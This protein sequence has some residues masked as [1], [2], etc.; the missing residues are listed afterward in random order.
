M[1]TLF[2]YGP[3][4][5]VPCI[6]PFVTK[7]AYYMDFAGLPWTFKQGQVLD[8]RSTT[9]Y[10][11][12]PIVEIDGETIA[13]ST[14]IIAHLEARQE[15]GLDRSAAAAD[16]A[17]MLAWNRLL[18]EHLYWAAVVQP[19]WREQTNWE[20]YIPIIV[21]GA[22]VDGPTREALE[23]FRRSIMSELEGQGMG[24]LP[25]AV[26]HARAAAD[27]MAIADFLGDKPCFMGSTVRT[28]DASVLSMLK[29][30]AESPFES[31]TRGLVRSR[32]NLMAYIARLD[33]Y[34]QARTVP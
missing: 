31:P 27:V 19:R 32:P 8:L 16:R 20:R 34:R 15:R 13:D 18:D 1:I 22:T 24:R 3:G 25:D 12:L 17:Q 11:K 29:H 26:V 30:I 4:W 23:A 10:G 2:G 9:P 7:V 14:Q 33:A 6:S 21:G 5:S 28:I